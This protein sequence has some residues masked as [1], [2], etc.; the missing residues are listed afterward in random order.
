MALRAGGASHLDYPLLPDHITS[1]WNGAVLA[2]RH[3]GLFVESWIEKGRARRVLIS[4]RC[5]EDKFTRANPIRLCLQLGTI[6]GHFRLLLLEPLHIPQRFFAWSI[7][8]IALVNLPDGHSVVIVR[9]DMH[10]R[11]TRVG[12]WHFEFSDGL[13]VPSLW[14]LRQRSVFRLLCAANDHDGADAEQYQQNQHHKSG[15]SVS[16]FNIPDWPLAV[17]RNSH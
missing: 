3:R 16:H 2:N 9:T 14:N 5:I 17:I 4:N 8:G 11:I 15:V 12:Q 7:D 10:G 6:E 1:E 13:I